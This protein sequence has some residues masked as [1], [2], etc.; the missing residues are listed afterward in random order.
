MILLRTVIFLNGDYSKQGLGCLR[1]DDFIIA[2]D[3]GAKYLLDNGIKPHIFVGDADSVDEG[4]LG[5]LETLGSTLYL[6]PEDKDKIDA[7][8]AIE[9]AIELGADEIVIRGW[10][11]ERIDMIL[12]LIYLMCKYPDRTIIAKDDNLQMGVVYSEMIL[13]ATE[14]EKWSILPICGDAIGVTLEGFKY[15]LAGMSMPCQEPFGVSN[16]AVAE[17]VKIRVRKGMV[18]YFRWIKQPF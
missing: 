18:V 3:G 14:G 7:Q 9:K 8:L 12:A 15:A 5:K 4:S 16:V 11:G 17:K 2:V 13:D 10:Q 6:Y 1:K